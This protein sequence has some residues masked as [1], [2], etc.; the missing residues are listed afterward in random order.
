MVHF[1]EV[2]GS[3]ICAGPPFVPRFC[4]VVHFPLLGFD[5]RGFGAVG[6]HSSS[7]WQVLVDIVMA[8]VDKFSHAT[9]STDPGRGLRARLAQPLVAH[10]AGL[11]GL[12]TSWV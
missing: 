6:A 3:R 1:A 4:D 12:A 7:C 5:R 2:E 8:W 10:G 11:H 9:M